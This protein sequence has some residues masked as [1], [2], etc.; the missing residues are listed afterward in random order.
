M[1]TSKKNDGGWEAKTG[2]HS[3]K[4]KKKNSPAKAKHWLSS[5]GSISSFAIQKKASDDIMNKKRQ[6]PGSAMAMH[7]TS[8]YF[9]W[10]FSTFLKNHQFSKWIPVQQKFFNFFFFH[11]NFKYG[12]AR[13]PFLVKAKEMGKIKRNT[14]QMVMV[15]T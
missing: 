6:N 10:V 14:S 13:D 8:T 1:G 4:D 15:S 11:V 5:Q 12:S 2:I 7:C 3:H 9:K